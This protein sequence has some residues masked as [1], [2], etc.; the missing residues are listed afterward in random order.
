MSRESREQ[1]LEYLFNY[2]DS[3]LSQAE[4]ATKGSKIN[5]PFK[6]IREKLNNLIDRA[7]KIDYSRLPLKVIN[8]ELQDIMN[9][10]SKIIDNNPELHL[11]AR[12]KKYQQAILRNAGILL[13]VHRDPVEIALEKAYEISDRFFLPSNWKEHMNKAMLPGFHQNKREDMENF[14]I[15]AYIKQG[16]SPYEVLGLEDENPTIEDIV[17]AFENKIKEIDRSAPKKIGH[18]FSAQE[19]E[20]DSISLSALILLDDKYRDIYNQKLDERPSEPGQEIG[21]PT[22]GHRHR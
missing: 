21:T 11:T 8:R 13:E 9:D 15:E 7:K 4:S 1:K 16:R 19:K 20:R 22:K 18:N 5:N 6:E 14:S 17:N 3:F 12:W 2:Y 10:I